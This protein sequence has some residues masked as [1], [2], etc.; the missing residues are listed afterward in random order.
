MTKVLYFGT[1]ADFGHGLLRQGPR[2]VSA[3]NIYWNHLGGRPKCEVVHRP[4]ATGIVQAWLCMI[5]SQKNASAVRAM[6]VP[7]RQ[8]QA[9][10]N[11]M[12]RRIELPSWG[13]QPARFNTTNQSACRWCTKKISG[14]AWTFC[15][16]AVRLNITGISK[17]NG[18]ESE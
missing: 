8:G 14:G 5:L 9:N 1:C 17:A 2:G 15:L 7:Y 3:F 13:R 6:F 11:A 16:P 10:A 4:G 18:A 12:M